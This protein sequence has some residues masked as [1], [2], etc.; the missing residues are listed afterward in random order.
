M[1]LYI[2]SQTFQTVLPYN[3]TIPFSIFLLHQYLLLG[4]PKPCA[5]SV[6]K[7]LVGNQV[8]KKIKVPV[9][10]LDRQ[11]DDQGC[12]Q[13][14]LKKLGFFRP[15]LCPQPFSR[16]LL[17]SCCI[18]SGSYDHF[19]QTNFCDFLWSQEHAHLHNAKEDKDTPKVT[20]VLPTSDCRRFLSEGD[21]QQLEPAPPANS[22]S[23]R[24]WLKPWSRK[25]ADQ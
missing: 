21:T 9:S 10:Q 19:L 1:Q 6:M 18:Y 3:I 4:F 23:Q 25:S 5:E 8:S 17:T 22:S 16:H 7:V 20:A 24:V 14:P 12:L 2:S 11:R 13:W 15:L